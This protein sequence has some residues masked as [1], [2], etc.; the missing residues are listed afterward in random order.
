MEIALKRRSC[1]TSRCFPAVGMIK[2]TENPGLRLSLAPRRPWIPGLTEPISH[3]GEPNR[4]GRVFWKAYG[5]A[6]AGIPTTIGL[7]SRPQF[8]AAAEQRTRH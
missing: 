8:S 2:L 6:A 4:V 5:G 3:G 7:T 1:R